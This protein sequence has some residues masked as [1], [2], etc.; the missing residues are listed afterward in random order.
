[1]SDTSVEMIETSDVPSSQG[2]TSNNITVVE[3]TQDISSTD[4]DIEVN[5]VSHE[6]DYNI[7][8]GNELINKI[9]K[10]C[11]KLEH[12][13]G[14]SR[15]INNCMLPFYDQADTE[16]KKSQG[17][18]IFLKKTLHKL[19][20]DPDHKFFHLKNLCNNLKAHKFKK[21]AN[22]ITLTTNLE[23]INGKFCLYFA[24]FLIFYKYLCS[25]KKDHYAKYSAKSI[26]I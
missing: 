20:S 7:F 14:M 3:E 24:F 21:R 8:D 17:L 6:T 13:K 18:I 12:S 25:I 16:Y 19:Q 23:G 11:L 1:M 22:F 2:D 9:I 4:E 5:E 15:V 10:V 26:Y